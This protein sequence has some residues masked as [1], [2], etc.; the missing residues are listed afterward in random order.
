MTVM[1]G[2]VA[3]DLEGNRDATK[4]IDIDPFVLYEAPVV[5]DPLEESA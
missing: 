1:N 4:C 2:S 3:W 5:K